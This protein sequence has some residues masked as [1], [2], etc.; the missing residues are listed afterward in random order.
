MSQPIQVIGGVISHFSDT[1]EKWKAIN[2]RTIP[3]VLYISHDKNCMK[4]G[5]GKRWCDVEYLNVDG[6]PVGTLIYN[7]FPKA[8]TNYFALN[9]SEKMIGDYRKVYSMA[10][11]CKLLI[12]NDDWVNNPEMQGYFSYCEDPSK[13]RIPKLDGRILRTWVENGILSPCTF[14][15]GTIVA[16]DIKCVLNDVS[17]LYGAKTSGVP[18]DAIK[19][20]LCLDDV[21]ITNGMIVR[22]TG[23][24]G[25]VYTSGSV[26]EVTSIVGTT[27]PSTVSYPIYM[28]YI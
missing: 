16:T 17:M 19:S 14:Q 2:P 10:E 4:I 13:F 25:I 9:G 22:S 15:H 23:A 5:T 28:K 12:P 6:T 3:N 1:E 26:Q 8:P 7:I 20:K 27:R 11:D 21:S 18:T 24:A